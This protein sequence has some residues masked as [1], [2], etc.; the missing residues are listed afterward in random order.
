MFS[1]LLSSARTAGTQISEETF[2]RKE[3]KPEDV[4]NFDLKDGKYTA[5][6]VWGKGKDVLASAMVMNETGYEHSFNLQGEVGVAMNG[7]KSTLV[8]NSS[9]KVSIWMMPS[10]M[11]RGPNILYSTKMY[12]QHEFKLKKSIEKNDLCVFFALDDPKMS[13]Y[14]KVVSKDESNTPLIE[15]FGLKSQKITSLGKC[16]G[17]TCSAS[18]KE[19]SFFR[20]RNLTANADYTFDVTLN[21]K[22]ANV[23][24]E[25]CD[26]EFLVELNNGNEISQTVIP[27]SHELSC[28][29]AANPNESIENFYIAIGLCVVLTAAIIICYAL[30]ICEKISRR[31]CSWCNGEDPINVYDY[32]KELVNENNEAFDD[33]DTKLSI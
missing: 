15:A 33:D 5:F 27:S 7:N 24:N 19:N 11:C 6:V 25:M 29:K 1:L 31:L 18:I 10:N 13:V 12:L 16:N 21:S 32:D 8:F 28:E 26:S 14:A 17:N 2:M 20:V 30:G 3:V 9:A 4:F 22:N 23:D